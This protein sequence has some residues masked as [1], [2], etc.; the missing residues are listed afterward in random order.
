[1]NNLN[2][3]ALIALG[4]A[5]IGFLLSFVYVFSA[6]ANQLQP[7][8]KRVKQIQVALVVHGYSAGTNWHDTQEICRRIANDHKWQTHFAPDAR[9]LILLGLGNDHSDLEVLTSGSNHLDRAERGEQ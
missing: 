5:V 1:M 3:K 8:A 6:N 2:R 7:D 4:A 9:V